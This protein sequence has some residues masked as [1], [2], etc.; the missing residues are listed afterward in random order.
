MF[1]FFVASAILGGAILLLQ[2]VLAMLGVHHDGD[3]DDH[4]AAHDGEDALNLLSIRAIAS[5]LTFF[6][7]AGAGVLGAGLGALV[8]VP[9][10]LVAGLG[11][12]VAVAYAMRS[13]RKLESD[14]TLRI[15]QAIGEGGTVYVRIPGQKS[16]PGKVML[17]LQNRLVELQAVTAEETLPTGTAVTVV[18]VV[19]PDTVEVVVTPQVGDE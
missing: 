3:A 15:E 4:G 5:G 2:S 16:G 9:L 11:A 7:I 1:T 18:D 13:I 17:K 6:G 10:S 8:A 14:G 19:G 12:M